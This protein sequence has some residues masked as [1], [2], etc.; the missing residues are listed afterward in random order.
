[1]LTTDL[2]PKIAKYLFHKKISKERV[3]KNE[4]HNLGLNRRKCRYFWLTII[5]RIIL[6][7]RYSLPAEYP[8]FGPCGVKKKLDPYTTILYS[9]TILQVGGEIK[10]QSRT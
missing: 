4:K 10:F 9:N 7:D 3:F 8:C 6:G 2:K 1:M 5:E